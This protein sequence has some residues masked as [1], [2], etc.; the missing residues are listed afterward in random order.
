MM[1]VMTI[2]K[3]NVTP[4]RVMATRATLRMFSADL[5]VE[6]KE[7]QHQLQKIETF[8][9]FKQQSCKFSCN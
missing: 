7:A 8:K 6:E 9:K 5:S 4:N 3:I 2:R 1:T